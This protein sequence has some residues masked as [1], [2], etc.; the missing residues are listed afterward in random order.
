MADALDSPRHS[1]VWIMLDT[2]RTDTPQ[3][4]PPIFGSFLNFTQFRSCGSRT[5]DVMQ[6]LLG[7]SECTDDEAQSFPELLSN[8]GYEVASFGQYNALPGLFP[9]PIVT[10]YADQSLKRASDWIRSRPPTGRYFAFVHLKGGHEPYDGSGNT[11]RERYDSA[12]GR[13]LEAVSGF[14]DSLA[15]NPVVVVM[16]D[17]GEE[18]GEHEGRAH[19]SSLYEET[20]ATRAFVH[21]RGWAGGS[22]PQSI[23]CAGLKSVVLAAIQGKPYAQRSDSPVFAMLNSPRG[24]HGGLSHAVVYSLR[25]D[26]H[27]KVSW[28]PHV[29]IWELYHLGHDPG[30]RKNLA[31]D[32]PVVLSTGVAQLMSV[33]ERCQKSTSSR[34]SMSERSVLR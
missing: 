8:A 10:A 12:I 18:F 6:Q 26:D 25:F 22:E 17:H 29:G 4:L 7:A 3:V 9:A 34:L 5:R 30:E 13:S 23:G 2:W 27:W 31:D 24:I 33:V 15:G 1:L 32:L 14:V 20:L 21:A 16:G 19:A 28:K 11:R